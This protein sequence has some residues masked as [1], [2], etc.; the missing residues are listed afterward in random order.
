MRSAAPTRDAV[1]ARG[2]TAFVTVQEGCDKFC[3]FC[4]VPYTRGIEVSRPVDEHRRRGRAAGGCRRAR[5][6]ADRPERQR[7]SRRGNGRTAVDARPPA[8][9][10]CR[11]ARHRAAAL[12]HQPSLRHRRQPD[13]GAPRSAGLMPFL[14]LPVQSGSDRI[15]AAMNRRHTRA[16]YLAAHRAH[17]RRARRDGVL[18]RFHRRLPG[19]ERGRFRAPRSSLVD[20]VGFAGAYSFK[21]SPRPG[22]PAADMD[23]AI[24]GRGDIGAALPLAGRDH[25]PP[26]GIQ[27]ALRS[28]ARS[29]CCSRN[30]D[31]IPGQI[32]GRSPYLQPVHVMATFDIDRQHP[33]R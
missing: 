31:I 5:G 32:V 28:A 18:L 14:H 4:V 21:Y 15:L 17:A 30:P 11:G 7:L 1:R 3:T 23:G 12:H 27:R 2:I 26:D 22:T 29:T 8:A 25:P 33:R 13:R 6:H 16:D 19:R 10:A 20:E 9:S 24:A